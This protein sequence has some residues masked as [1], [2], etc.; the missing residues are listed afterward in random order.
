MPFYE[1]RCENCGHELEAMQKVS[2]APLRDCP[3]CGQP[4]LV[5]LISAAGFQLKG[6]GW[7][8]TDFKDKGKKSAEPAAEGGH[9]C[10]G[11]SCPA[12]E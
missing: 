7:Y 12:C 11:G 1:Y 2:D 8:A 9:A 6:G 3:E 4:T 5:K 10:G